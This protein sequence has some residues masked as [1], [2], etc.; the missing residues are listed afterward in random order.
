MLEHALP[1]TVT[2]GGALTLLLDDSRA[3]DGL[4]NRAKEL[5][6]ALVPFVPGLTRV[7][8]NPPQGPSSRNGT[9]M[10]AESIK[11]QTII[12]LKKKDEVLA[13]AIEALDLELM[14]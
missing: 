14:D 4:A 11:A 6:A 9:R 10:T 3:Y 13:A 8:L 12:S 2:A 7:A 1:T 5:S